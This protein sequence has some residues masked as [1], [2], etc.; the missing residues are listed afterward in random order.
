MFPAPDISM[1]LY[2]PGTLMHTLHHFHRI[3]GGTGASY[4][5]RDLPGIFIKGHILEGS[6]EDHATSGVRR[7]LLVVY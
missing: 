6:A 7:R 1:L 5:E 4:M 2:N 3:L